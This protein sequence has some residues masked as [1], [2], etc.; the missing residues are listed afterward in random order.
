[1]KYYLSGAISNQPNFKNYFKEHEVELRRLGAAD[2]FNP[3]DVDFPKNVQWETC[4]KYD[5]KVLMDCDCLVLLPNW[6]KS[7]GAQI[8]KCLCQ[9]LGIR[10]IIFKDLVLELAQN[11]S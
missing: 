5:I 10:V 3:A 9:I 7:R 2:I 6:T 1:L 11:A 8:E 4:M